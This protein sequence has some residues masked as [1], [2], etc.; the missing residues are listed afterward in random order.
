MP[1]RGRKRS[2]VLWSNEPDA[3]CRCGTPVIATTWNRLRPA[4][5]GPSRGETG[6][7][8]GLARGD[9]C[10]PLDVHEPQRSKNADRPQAHVGRVACLVF[11]A[12][13]AFRQSYSPRPGLVLRLPAVKRTRRTFQVVPEPGTV[14]G[15][16]V[17]PAKSG[18]FRLSRFRTP[19]S[20][21][22]H[23]EP[24]IVVLVR[25]VVVVAVR[26]GQVVGVVVPIAATPPCGGRRSA[27]RRQLSTR[28]AA[29]A[30]LR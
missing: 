9:L 30:S 14:R 22:C 7:E 10:G 28:M 4:G 18:R 27:H 11:D 20:G 19:S 15:A 2:S 8:A 13:R 3:G 5:R 24:Y 6:A 23:A 25:R 21:A 16:S 1:C 12:G 17:H 26:G 29:N